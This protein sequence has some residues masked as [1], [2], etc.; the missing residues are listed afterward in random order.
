MS[1][2]PIAW[3]GQDS[4]IKPGN[5]GTNNLGVGF[6]AMQSTGDAFGNTALGDQSALSI[7]RIKPRGYSI[8]LLIWYLKTCRSSFLSRIHS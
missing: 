4:I 5:P 8:V 2:G 1:R 7:R 3:G 6:E